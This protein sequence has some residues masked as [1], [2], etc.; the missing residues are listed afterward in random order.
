MAP[1]S[2][3]LEPPA[4]PGRFKHNASLHH[5]EAEL[6]K[7]NREKQKL[8]QS[9]L[10]GVSGTLLKDEAARIEKRIGQLE[11]LLKGKVERPTL[12]EPGIAARY[13]K[14]VKRLLES[15]NNPDHREE[16][17][18]LVRSLVQAIVLTPSAERDRPV[19]DLIGDLEHFR[20]ILNRCGFPNHF[21]SDSLM[22]AGRRPASDDRTFVK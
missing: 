22:L 21:C 16:A 7:L 1:L 17:S 3:E 12:F 9:I 14:E 20:P 8:I 18:E 11:A 5:Y 4:N 6:G 10:D 19:I 2:H 13:K 15:L